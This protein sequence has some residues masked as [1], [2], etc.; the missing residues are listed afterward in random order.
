MGFEHGADPAEDPS[1]LRSVIA[2]TQTKIELDPATYQAGRPVKDRAVGQA[3]IGDG[4]QR[5]LK[6][7]D[8][9]RG[10]PDL[11]NEPLHI[12]RLDPVPQMERLLTHQTD[13]VK[14]VRQRILGRKTDQHPSDPQGGNEPGEVHP[15][16]GQDHQH[17]DR[18]DDDLDDVQEQ[19]EEL[20]THFLL[21]TDTDR[22][23]HI[24]EELD[25]LIDPPG[26]HDQRRDLHPEAHRLF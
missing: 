18:R 24:K 16:F 1:D 21:P 9:G 6:G 19:V 3:G 15:H 25:D 23:R 14:K 2:V 11:D 26:Q 12:L 20:L 10:Q 4:H 13:R 5:V 7:S 8:A 22:E 17:H